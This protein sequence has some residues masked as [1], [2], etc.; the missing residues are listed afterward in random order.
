[1]KLIS[2]VNLNI[3]KLKKIIKLSA[4]E[5]ALGMSPKAI[6]NNFKIKALN[7]ERYPDGKSELLR[8]EISK[9]YKC[10]CDKVICGAGSDEVIQMICQL[11][12]NPKDEVDCSSI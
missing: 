9:K 8:K 3:R 12:L 10:N 6:K 7:L 1:M 2:Q 4:N 5:S 11:F